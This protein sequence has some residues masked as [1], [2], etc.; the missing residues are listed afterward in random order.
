MNNDGVID[1]EEF[2]RWYFT[3]MRPYNGT[4]KSIIK[5]SGKIN[6][7]IDKVANEARLAIMEQEL[8]TKTNRFSFSFNAPEN[9]QTII[10]QTILIGGQE[11]KS[12][13]DNLVAQYKDTIDPAKE[14]ARFG[15]GSWRADDNTPVFV[16]FSVKTA[17][18]KAADHVK[19][20]TERVTKMIDTFNVKEAG[21]FIW[22]QP[23]IHALDEN[24]IAV[25]VKAYI[26]C[27]IPNLPQ[28]ILDVLRHAEQS[29]NVRAE[30]GTSL[31]DIMN[32]EDSLV[33]RTKD[34]FRIQASMSVISNLKKLLME[35][36]NSENE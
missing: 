25:G 31:S 11:A 24:T 5:M 8:K 33:N 4:R 9:P 26:P 3:G 23:K 19:T 35:L 27:R 6:S 28:D 21:D 7:L 1:F 17:E 14:V 32:L 13:E 12:I 30:L 15:E 18:G 34:G 2:Q 29:V 36:S 10:D 20:L 22:K 16:Q